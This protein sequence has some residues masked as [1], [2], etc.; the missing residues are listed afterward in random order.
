MNKLKLFFLL[1][2]INI[3]CQKK[4]IDFKNELIGRTFNVINHENFPLDFE[5]KDSIYNSYQFNKAS[6]YYRI[7][8]YKDTAYLILGTNPCLINKSEKESYDYLVISRR[9]KDTFKLKERESKWVEKNIYGFWVEEKYASLLTNSTKPPPPLPPPP[10]VSE[11]DFQW[12]PYYRIAKD[13]I[14]SYYG[15]QISTSKFEINNTNEFISMNMKTG[16]KVQE[17][18]WRIKSIEDSIMII[19]RA[20]RDN[21]ISIGNAFNIKLIKKR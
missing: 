12:P 5:F 4:E 17:L 20:S 21:S 7:E 6:D 11:S 8:K 15:Y 2:F 9:F 19:D 14:S 13:S 3:S 1:I 10:G 18:F 16:S